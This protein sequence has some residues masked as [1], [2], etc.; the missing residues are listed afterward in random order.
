MADIIK[1]PTERTLEDAERRRA[2]A[3]AFARLGQSGDYVLF[4]AYI[5]AIINEYVQKLLD[6]SR[7]EKT[8]RF[9]QG[10]IAGLDSAKCLPERIVA[11]YSEEQESGQ[12]DNPA[13]QE[14]FRASPTPEGAIDE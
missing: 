3:A 11:K 5:D 2:D 14:G 13:G 6:P 9:L 1:L 10:V 4:A 8:L 12:P 7:D